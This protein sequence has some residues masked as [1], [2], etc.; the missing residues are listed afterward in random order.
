M[1][2]LKKTLKVRPRVDDLEINA[3]N[4][5][6]RQPVRHRVDDLENHR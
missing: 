2:K 5:D 3:I 1:L 4:S 6:G